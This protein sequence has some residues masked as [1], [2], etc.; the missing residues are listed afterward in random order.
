M[1][2][3]RI[4]WAQSNTFEKWLKNFFTC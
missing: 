2:K 1:V 4:K 3:S